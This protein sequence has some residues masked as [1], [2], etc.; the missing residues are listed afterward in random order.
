M[1]TTTRKQ[2][3]AQARK[4]A[5]ESDYTP[6]YA[7][8]GLTQ[9]VASTLQATGTKAG[10]QLA[11]WQGKNEQQAKATADDVTKF[12]RA[13]PEHVKALP[14]TSKAQVAAWQK[15]VAEILGTANATYVELA[16]RGKLVVDETI[17]SA[18]QL[19]G[20]AEKRAGDVVSDVADRVDP[21]FEQVQEGVTQA[22]KATTGRTATETL[23]PRS[24]RRAAATRSARQTPAK[25][26]PA[27]KDSATTKKATTARK[28][29]ARK[30]PAKANAGSAG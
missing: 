5:L 12:V 21:A 27:K 15:Q 14:E 24:T 26:T 13:L 20:K 10:E 6:F 19:G 30:A 29:T 22:R 1:S 11:A 17:G 9:A 28:T 3:P 23:T 18:R 8:A 2:T 7:V 25:Q 4:A 16:A